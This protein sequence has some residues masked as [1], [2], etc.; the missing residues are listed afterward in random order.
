MYPQEAYP[1]SFTVICSYFG[2]RGSVF[3]PYLMKV[4]ERLC[5]YCYCLSLKI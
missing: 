2:S 3:G 1:V 4:H 5:P